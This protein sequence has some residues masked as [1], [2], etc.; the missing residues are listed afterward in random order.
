MG[1]IIAYCR[2]GCHYS[3][4]TKNILE[5]L[6]EKINASK[7]NNLSVTINMVPNIEFEK[8]KLRKQ[9]EPVIGNYSTW[10]IVI[11]ESTQGKQFFIGGN[12]NLDEIM[13][14]VNTFNGQLNVNELLTCVSSESLNKINPNLNDEGKRRLICNLLLIKNKIKF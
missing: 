3:N 2:E 11:Y 14:F 9:L 1:K 6:K 8:N 10:P 5:K 12:S 4:N 13:N 7:T